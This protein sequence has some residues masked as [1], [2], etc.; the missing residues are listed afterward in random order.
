MATSLDPP[1]GGSDSFV[2]ATEECETIVFCELVKGFEILA[3]AIGDRGSSGNGGARVGLEVFA[4]VDLRRALV[5]NAANL[6]KTY[7][8]NIMRPERERVGSAG[9]SFVIMLNGN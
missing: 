7:I 2:C 9:S 1:S 5:A 6:R 4:V 8:F 3:G